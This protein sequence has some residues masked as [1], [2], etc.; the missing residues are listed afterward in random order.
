MYLLSGTKPAGNRICRSRNTN[1]TTR[2][3]DGTVVR[4]TTINT[5]SFMLNFRIHTIYRYT[6]LILRLHTNRAC[7]ACPVESESRID[8]PESSSHD[9]C[10]IWIWAPARSRPGLDLHQAR[11]GYPVGLEMWE[12][13]TLHV[14]N[15]HTKFQNKII[16]ICADLVGHLFRRTPSSRERISRTVDEAT[17]GFCAA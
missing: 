10:H 2:P 13:I 1:L 15:K 14:D 17:H 6:S 16:S 11:G 9:H 12:F 5:H 7:I 4:E 3:L 8:G